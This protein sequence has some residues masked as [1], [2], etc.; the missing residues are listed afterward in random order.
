MGN[1]GVSGRGEVGSYKLAFMFV[2]IE[3]IWYLLKFNI[4]SYNI[5][6]NIGFVKTFRIKTG[7][8]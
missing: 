6:E 3:M 1:L 7:Y 8:V 4:T 2:R 5:E